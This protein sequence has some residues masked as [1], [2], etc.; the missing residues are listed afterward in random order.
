MASRHRRIAPV[1]RLG[2]RLLG[3]EGLADE[4]HRI[5]DLA[6]VIQLHLDIAIAPEPQVGDVGGKPARIDEL[7]EPQVERQPEAALLRHQ[8]DEVGLRLVGDIVPPELFPDLGA[9]GE[10]FLPDG[11][12]EIVHRPPPPGRRCG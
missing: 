8:V 3:R 11:L 7:V 1:A 6:L 10:D 5:G 12:E 9:E 4:L 2:P